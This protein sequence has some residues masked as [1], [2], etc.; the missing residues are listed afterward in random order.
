MNYMFSEESRIAEATKSLA[1]LIDHVPDCGQKAAIPRARRCLKGWQ[2]LDRGHKTPNPDGVG[3]SSGLEHMGRSN[4]SSGNHDTADVR[5]L[6]ATRRSAKPEGGSLGSTNSR[7]PFSQFESPSIRPDEASKVGLSGETIQL[8]SGLMPCRVGAIAHGTADRRE[9]GANVAC[10]VPATERCLDGQFAG[11][12]PQARPRLLCWTFLFVSI[13]N[14]WSLS[15]V[16][17]N[18]WT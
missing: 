17:E 13:L 5:G 16:I 12:G 11:R 1:A 14:Y 2:R 7:P 8:D 4:V 6:S 9:T 3:V 10:D 15:W 18:P